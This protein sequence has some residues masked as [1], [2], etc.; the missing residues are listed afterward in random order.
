[1]SKLVCIDSMIS[2]WHFRD[3]EPPENT[4]DLINYTKSKRLLK[5]LDKEGYKLIIPS[6]V[7]SEILCRLPHEEQIKRF[8]KFHKDT[9][10]IVSNFGRSASQILAKILHDR[11]Y[12]ENKVYK[13]ITIED[14][15]N[16]SKSRT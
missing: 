14:G 12:T 4:N 13:Q 5:A 9:K 1:M 8:N 11:Y 15:S 7:L 2:G 3:V 6:I 16:I 10:F